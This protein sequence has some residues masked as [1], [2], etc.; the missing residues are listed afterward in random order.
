MKTIEKQQV[1][2]YFKEHTEGMK[3]FKRT[4]KNACEM[5]TG[6]RKINVAEFGDDNIVLTF[7]VK[8]GKKLNRC[9]TYNNHGVDFTVVPLTRT[10]AEALMICLQEIIDKEK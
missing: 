8:D 4:Y 3:L 2:K 9:A 1:S 5:K 10:T 6:N 7:S